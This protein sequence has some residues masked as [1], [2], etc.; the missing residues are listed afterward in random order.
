MTTASFKLS[1]E[2]K[3]RAKAAERQARCVAD[4]LNASQHALE[5]GKGWDAN[6]VHACLIARSTNRNATK[7]NAKSWRQQTDLENLEAL[8]IPTH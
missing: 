4:A 6:E 8:L 5:S 2:L 3:L 1:D 7:R